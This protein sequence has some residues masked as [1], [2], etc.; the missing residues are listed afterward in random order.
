MKKIG[1]RLLMTGL[2]ATSVVAAGSMMAAADDGKRIAFF[3]SDLSNVFHQAQGAEAE[4]YAAE[5]YGAKVVVFDG[6][7]DSAVMTQNI[8]QVLAGGCL[9]YTSPSPRDLSTSRMP[10]SA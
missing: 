4:R 1:K 3:V 9:L 10:S 8:D 6:K 5:K 7:A 2:L